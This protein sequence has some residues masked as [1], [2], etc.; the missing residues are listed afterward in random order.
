M[1]PALNSYKKTMVETSSPLE[2]VILLHERCLQHLNHLQKSIQENNVMEK[3]AAL[4]KAMDIISGLDGELD[5]SQ[6]EIAN[7]LHTL[8]ECMI[9]QLTQANI[10]NDIVPVE[11]TK[12]IIFELKDTWRQI[13]KKMQNSEKN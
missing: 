10:K 1:N 2:N 13:Q 8:Y 4:Q 9:A 7:N 5:Y 3:V 11:L 6:G 12:K